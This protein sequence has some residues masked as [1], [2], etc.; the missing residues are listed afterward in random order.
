MK[1]TCELYLLAVA[2]LVPITDVLAQ[3]DTDQPLRAVLSCG[4]RHVNAGQPVWVDFM[5]RNASDEPVILSVPG[6]ESEVSGDEMGLPLAHVF[7]GEAFSALSIRNESNRV[8]SLATGYQ[9]GAKAPIFAI[10]PGATVGTR[11]DIRKYYPA[12]RTPGDYRLTW[13]PYGGQVESNVLLIRVGALKQAE[14]ITD[15]GT[16]KLNF[17]YGEAP[18]H[19]ENFIELA[20]KGF[21][22]NLAFHRIVTGYFVQG[23]CPIGDG[24]GIRLDGVKLNA[25]NS[26]RPQTRGMVSMALVDDDPDSGSCQFFIANTR[27]PE[28][29]GR[30]TIF[31]ELVGEASL[32]TLDALMAAEVNEA[33]VPVEKLHIRGIRITDLPRD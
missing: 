25:E 7:S 14:I 6:T 27:V 16:M 21:Y 20:K 5:I 18:N 31:A 3:S 33:G 26:N 30:Y 2:A 19:V 10:A 4:R 23:G 15:H 9:P 32:A 13:S 8:W 28:W 24:T 12:L 29:D 1:T 22:D 17:F 11:V